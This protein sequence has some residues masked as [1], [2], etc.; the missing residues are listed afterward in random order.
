MLDV[1]DIEHVLVEALYVR[2]RH[3]LPADNAGLEYMRP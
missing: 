2:G 3:D 1:L